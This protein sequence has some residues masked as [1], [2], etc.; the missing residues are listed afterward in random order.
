MIYSDLRNK[1]VQKQAY[2]Q[3]MELTWYPSDPRQFLFI[4]KSVWYVCM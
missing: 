4:E 3:G 2:L 1:A